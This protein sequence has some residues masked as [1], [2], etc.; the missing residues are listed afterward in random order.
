M[1]V[2]EGVKY[3]CKQCD[4]KASQSGH[5]TTH[6]MSVH[7]GVKYSCNHCDLKFSVLGNLNRHQM[8]VHEGVNILLL[9][10]DLDSINRHYCILVNKQGNTKEIR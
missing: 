1:S 6:K 4:Y 9:F 2:H 3:S 10:E 8:S 7:E 5:L